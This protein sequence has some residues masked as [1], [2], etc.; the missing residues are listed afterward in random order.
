M[1]DEGF[2]ISPKLLNE[3]RKLIRYE[4][5]TSKGRPMATEGTQPNGKTLRL[6]RLTQDLNSSSYANAEIYNAPTFAANGGTGTQATGT[7]K[8]VTVYDPAMIPS[9]KKLVS[10]TFCWVTNARGRW[11]LIQATACPS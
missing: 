7:I 8:N 2:L 9:G 4:N 11:E 1:A 5:S 3:I 6:V 10:N